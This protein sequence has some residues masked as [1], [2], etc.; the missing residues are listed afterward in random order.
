MSCFIFVDK[1][2]KDINFTFLN[3]DKDMRISNKHIVKEV[4]AI[5]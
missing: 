5:Q 3:K 4:P 1:F 2:L